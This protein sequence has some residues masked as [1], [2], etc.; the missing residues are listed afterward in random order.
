MKMFDFLDCFPIFKRK[1]GA[2]LAPVHILFVI[3]L[4]ECAYLIGE[5]LC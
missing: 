3:R 1:T 4:G 5:F 2:G